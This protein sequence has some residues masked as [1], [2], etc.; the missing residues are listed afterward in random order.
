MNSA[1][2]KQSVILQEFIGL[3]AAQK[4]EGAARGDSWRLMT[5]R[6]VPPLL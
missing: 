4:N 3:N 6:F 2:R 5:A 1:G